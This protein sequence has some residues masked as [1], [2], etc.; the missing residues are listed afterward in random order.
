[1]FR[2]LHGVIGV[3]L[4]A[5]AA[6]GDAARADTATAPPA[7]AAVQAPAAAPAAA[8]ARAA[9]AFDG[10]QAW[11]H[12]ERIVAIGPRPSGSP[13]LRQTRAYITRALATFGVTVQ[14]QRFTATTPRGP[15]EMVNLIARLPGR[16]TDRILLTG[17]YDTKRMAN[18]RFVGASD[19]GS[20]AAWLIEAARVLAGQPT[21]EFTYELIWFDG[22]EAT[23]SGWTE[24]GTTASPDNTYGSRYYVAAAREANAIPSLRAM[25]LVDLIGDRDLELRRD[26]NST[27]WLVDILW[28]T[29]R[30]L[31]YNHIFVDTSTSVEDDHF[32]FL[33]AKIPSVDL[34][35]LDTFPYWHTPDDTLDKLSPRSLQAVGDVVI[36]ALPEIEA[37]LSK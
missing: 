30:R 31:A 4:V 21:R 24:C 32:P 2:V 19:G 34:I 9:T 33:A 12:L 35:D 27:P 3:A 5:V 36:A 11:Q 13:E 37:R 28:S 1:M 7:A 14:E 17:H 26:S 25:I 29:A 15:I 18:V 16:R 6:C 23:C 8:P 20:S 10:A 22:E